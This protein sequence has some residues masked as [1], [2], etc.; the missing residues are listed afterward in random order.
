[1]A[2]PSTTPIPTPAPIFTPVP[3]G[4]GSGG[5]SGSGNSSGA[6]VTLQGA[7]SSSVTASVNAV[8]VVAIAAIFVSG[9]A[10]FVAS[11]ALLQASGVPHSDATRLARVE[12]V[13]LG[14]ARAASPPPVLFV[15][16][17]L[18]FTLSL[19]RGNLCRTA[20]RSCASLCQVHC[21][22][23]ASRLHSQ[24]APGAAM[25][26]NGGGY[27]NGGGAPYREQSGSPVR[28]SLSI[29]YDLLIAHRFSSYSPA[30]L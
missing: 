15:T 19:C 2:P 16:S 29:S 4:S 17:G 24:V 30:R 6:L 10:F 23:L 26:G 8:I 1:M 9:V 12:A 14:K 13:L 27:A 18:R 7:S 22:T 3:I 5:R 11:S 21:L 20:R 25:G 28:L